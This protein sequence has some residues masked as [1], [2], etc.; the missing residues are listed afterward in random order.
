MKRIGLIVGMLLWSAT[1]FAQVATDKPQFVAGTPCS[2]NSVAGVYTCSVT[3]VQAGDTV[4]ACVQVASGTV[5]PVVTETSQSLSVNVRTAQLSSSGP[6]MAS[7]Q[8]DVVNAGTGTIT[9][10][11]KAGS[12]TLMQTI[13]PYIIR[14]VT[15]TPFDQ[16]GPGKKNASSATMTGDTTSGATTSA[17]EIAVQCGTFL[18]SEA[19]FGTNSISAWTQQE[20]QLTGPSSVV[21]TTVTEDGHRSRYEYQSSR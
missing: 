2:G 19:S 15:A 16:A 7:N 9:F 11:S 4:G 20:S 18:G 5:P 12:G 14:G 3:S 8:V 10:S 21:M 6:A 1:A 13:T 17:V